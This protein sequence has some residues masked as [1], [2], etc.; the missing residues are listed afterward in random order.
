MINEDSCAVELKLLT[1]REVVDAL[2]NSCRREDS[3]RLVHLLN[4]LLY[5]AP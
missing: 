3:S 4:S 2:T 1:I 5:L